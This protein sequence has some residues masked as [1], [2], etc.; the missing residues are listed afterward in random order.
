MKVLCCCHTYLRG[1]SWGHS[2]TGGP[3]AYVETQDKNNA[4]RED[5]IGERKD[6]AT[7]EDAIQNSVVTGLTEGKA[8]PEA[9]G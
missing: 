9:T 4:E 1:R 3:A 2:L 7:I 8:D 5:A 6:S